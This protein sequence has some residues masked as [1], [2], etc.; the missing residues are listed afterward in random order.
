MFTQHFPLLL[1]STTKNNSFLRAKNR[2]TIHRL[3]VAREN[4]SQGRQ[5]QKSLDSLKLWSK[6]SELNLLKIIGS[7]WS[8]PRKLVGWC[9][10]QIAASPSKLVCK[11]KSCG[12]KNGACPARGRW[13]YVSQSM[14]SL[15]MSE[16]MGQFVE[17][18][19]KCG[20]NDRMNEGSLCFLKRPARC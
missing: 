1:P 7:T 5:M 4:S 3:K 20:E 11:K 18:F 19:K 16:W 17:T 6:L 2:Q 8:Y 10:L 12:I 15:K 14:P 9:W 13:P